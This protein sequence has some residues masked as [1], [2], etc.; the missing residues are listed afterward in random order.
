MRSAPVL[1]LG[2]IALFAL[3]L[4]AAGTSATAVKEILAI[5]LPPFVAI[6][7]QSDRPRST[8][9]LPKRRRS[10]LPRD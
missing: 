3:A 7:A 8:R 1:L 9:K 4:L 2:M 6:A 10:S 5:V